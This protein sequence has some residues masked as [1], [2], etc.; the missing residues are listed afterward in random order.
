V[1]RL[2]PSYCTSDQRVAAL[3]TK[4]S[5]KIHRHAPA[6]AAHR[7]DIHRGITCRAGVAAFAR[8]ELVR[9]ETCGGGGQ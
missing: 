1:I 7:I 5:L 2:G 4:R 9:D 3:I 6:R 8:E